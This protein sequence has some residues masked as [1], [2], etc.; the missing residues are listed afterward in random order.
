MKASGASQ[1]VNKWFFNLFLE[2]SG[3]ERS[4][5]A[6]QNGHK[7]RL[8]DTLVLI[9]K[10]AHCAWRLLHF[11]PL[12]ETISPVNFFV[13][14]SK[15]AFTDQCDFL[16]QPKLTSEVIY[17]F[18]AEMIEIIFFGVLCLFF[19]AWFFLQF[20]QIK[21]LLRFNKGFRQLQLDKELGFGND[22]SVL[23]LELFVK[24]LIGANLDLFFLLLR[25]T[26]IKGLCTGIWVR[27]LLGKLVLH[28]FFDALRDL[29]LN[30]LSPF[31][32]LRC[33]FPFAAKDLQQRWHSFL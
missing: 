31:A 3:G 21:S 12:F 13:W 25:E 10:W 26:T 17:Q 11:T 18:F 32:H 23:L 9:G 16:S 7:T 15:F 1:S 8:E 2:L 30:E 29:K 4:L 6:A 24:L 33:L 20:L 27:Y 22:L 28:F 14:L 19:F 5:K